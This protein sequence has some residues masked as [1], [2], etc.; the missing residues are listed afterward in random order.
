VQELTHS[1][2]QLHVFVIV[3]MIFKLQKNDDSF[4]VHDYL[5]KEPG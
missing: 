1:K 3:A 4:C 5:I 2:F